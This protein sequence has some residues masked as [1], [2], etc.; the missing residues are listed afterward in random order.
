[1]IRK[2]KLKT[3]IFLSFIFHFSSFIFT[4]SV[5][6]GPASTNFELKE[7]GFGAGGVATSSSTNYMFQGILGEVETA[8]LSST[9]FMANPGL[10]YTLQPNTPPGP[11]LTNSSNWYNKLLIIIN[12]GN[13]PS[14]TVYAIAI[15]DDNWTTTKYVQNDNT[16]GSTLGIEDYQTYTNWGSESGE[17]IIG[18]TPNT[19]YKAKVK[20]MNG[21]YTETGY[22]PQVSAATSAITLSF[23]IDIGTDSSADTDPPYNIDLGTL[24]IGSVTTASNKVWVD[25]STNAE[26]GGYVYVY[27]IQNG[28][29]SND[30]NYTITSSTANLTSASEGYGLQSVNTSGLA[31]V[32]PFNGASENVGAV[33]TGIREVFNSVSIPVIGGRGSIILKAKASATTPSAG[34]YSDTLTLIASGAF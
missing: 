3:F 25:I 19:T 17:N 33:D 18:L 2:L 11:T 20:A 4:L 9:S 27:G 23:D 26:W 28:L 1:M 7:Y 34:D 10:T 14:D 31:S 22:G 15:S 30:T 13:N 21:E 24:S 12:T 8:S 5:I 29:R 6:A 16:I 32:A